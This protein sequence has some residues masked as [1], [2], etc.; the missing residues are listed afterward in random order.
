MTNFLLKVLGHFKV[1]QAP[2][3]PIS[4]HYHLKDVVSM[5][6]QQKQWETN[7][8]I[9]FNNYCGQLYFELINVLI[10]QLFQR[11]IQ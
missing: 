2:L 7:S 4:K 11:Q 5:V 10:L 9:N 8:L 6:C 1:F 3:S